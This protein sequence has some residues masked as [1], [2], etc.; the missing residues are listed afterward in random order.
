MLED[1]LHKAWKKMSHLLAS[2]DPEAQPKPDAITR[3]EGFFPGGTC[4]FFDF[5]IDRGTDLCDW[6]EEAS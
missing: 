1:R 5:L 6:Y 3:Q 4:G 2:H